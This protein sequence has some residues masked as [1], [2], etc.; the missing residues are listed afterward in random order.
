MYVH[1]EGRPYYH[2]GALLTFE[3]MHNAET[4]SLVL[5]ALAS[6]CFMLKMKHEGCIETSIHRDIEICIELETLISPPKFNYYVVDCRKRSIFWAD[7][8]R[9]TEIEQ[10]N[11]ITIANTFREEYW[12]HVEYYPCHHFTTAQDLGELRALL[13]AYATD[14]STS[15]GSTSPMSAYE[16][17]EHLKVLALFDEN[18][19]PYK[20][21]A[22]AR[23]FGLFIRGQ[24]VNLYGSQDARLDRYASLDNKPEKF[25]HY[26]APPQ[27][28]RKNLG[29]S[30]RVYGDLE[31]IQALLSEGMETSQVSGLR[32][33]GS[34][35]EFV[36][37]HELTGCLDI[38]TY[39][40]DFGDNRKRY[41]LPS[42]Q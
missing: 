39:G 13:G 29:G 5:Q 35:F 36:W 14:A 33:C 15:E 40:W 6:I 1:P 3:D 24:T 30:N 25:T 27:A 37:S 9:P 26:Y 28:L 41:Q 2:Q 34:M 19:S 17:R 7:S 8:R 38:R 20:T 12:K 16:I 21:W 23:L 4:A 10:A 22:I 11:E 31:D 32:N 42:F 18:E